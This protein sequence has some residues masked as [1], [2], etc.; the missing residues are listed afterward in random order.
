[1]SIKTDNKF[2]I[3]DVVKHFKYEMLTQ[4]EKNESKYCYVIR[5]Y[6]KHTE[7]GEELVIYQAL[8]APYE[9]YARPLTMFLEEVDHEKYP[10][11][12]Q[13]YRFETI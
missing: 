13:Q 2:N 12:K 6:A 4:Q 8:Y 11:I 7:T 9:T 10:E 5:G 3:G 1:M